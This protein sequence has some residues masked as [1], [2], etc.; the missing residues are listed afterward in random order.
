M[1]ITIAD[2][3]SRAGVSKT[4]VS[5]VLNGKGELEPSTAARVRRVI[6]ELGYVPSARAVGLARGRAG[7][8]GMLVPSLTWPWIGEVLQGAVDTVESNGYGLMLFTC[9]QG[10]QSMRQFANKASAKAFDGLLVI[11]PEGQL[12]YI[13]ELHG[14]GL[15][16]V[17]IDDRE[18]RPQFASVATTNRAGGESAARHLL[19]NGRTR[20]VVIT[21]TLAWGCTVE[22]LDGFTAVYAEGGRPLPAGSVVEGDFTFETGRAVMRRFIEDGVEFDAVFAHNDLSAAGALQALREAGRAVPGEVAIVGFD[23]VPLASQTEPPLTTVRQPLREMGAAAA[24]MLM[25]HFAGEPLPVEATVIPTDLVV[26]GSTSA[27]S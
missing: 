16:V 6:E 1:P 12:D 24:R 22:R 10:D 18:L 4:T 3:A 7:V 8:I 19:A 21:G 17:L 27:S 20:P 25:A 15:P 2:V 26:R 13:T 9:N 14:Q 23:D 5:R 11:E